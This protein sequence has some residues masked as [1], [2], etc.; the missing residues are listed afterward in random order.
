MITD[1]ALSLSRRKEDK[2]NGTG[3][4]HFM[5]NRYGMDGMTFSINADTSTGHFVVSDYIDIDEDD[6]K[7]PSATSKNIMDR[8]SQLKPKEI[9]DLPF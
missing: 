8:L 5:K 3:R 6:V 2:V 9:K 7:L 1:I 4:F